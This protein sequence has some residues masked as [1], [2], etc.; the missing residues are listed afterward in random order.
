MPAIQPERLRL[1]SARLV[2]SFNQPGAFVRGLRQVLERYGDHTYRPGQ[3]GRPPSLLPSHNVPPPVLR[4]VAQDV[5]AAASHDPAAALALCDALWA[6]PSLEARTLASALLGSLPIEN[7]AQV[8][9]R[10]STWARAGGDEAFL[11]TILDQGL[12]TLRLQAPAQALELAEGWL[13]SSKTPE[14]QLGMHVLLAVLADPA[15]EDLPSIY[16]LIAPFLR[17]AP[18]LL[19]PDL[20]AVLAALA[21]RS[22]QETAYMLKQALNASENAETAWLARQTLDDFPPDVLESL[23]SELKKVGGI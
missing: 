6:E 23:R 7:T 3:A 8:V 1:E 15:F 10:L 19:R 9:Q 20:L 13:Q 21:R 17:T 14:Q 5:K 12:Q 4:Q 22:P 2:E 11:T 18:A 16:S